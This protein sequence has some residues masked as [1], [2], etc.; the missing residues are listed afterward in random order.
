MNRLTRKIKYAAL[1][2]VLFFAPIFAAY[3][4]GEAAW[5]MADPKHMDARGVHCCGP[6]DCERAPKGAVKV[7]KDGLFV[8]LTGQTFPFPGEGPQPSGSYDS[9]D[10]DFWWCWAISPG[11]FP[12]Q[13]ARLRCVFMPGPGV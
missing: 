3:G 4:H 12:G 1:S 6:A 5:I 10:E 7:T 9:I 8:A 2:A 13:P 11:Q